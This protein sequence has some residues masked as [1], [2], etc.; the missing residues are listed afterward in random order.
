M[1]HKIYFLVLM[2]SFSSATVFADSLADYLMPVPKKMELRTGAFNNS[3]GRIIIPAISGNKSLLNIGET[4]QTLLSEINI[5][6]TVAAAGSRGEAPLV[7]VFLS[8][9]LSSQA[10]KITILSSQITIEGGDEE[11]LFYA[12][13]TFRQIVRYAKDAG[14]LPLVLIEDVPDFKRRGVMLDVSRNKVPT[15]STLKNL[16]ELFASWKLNELQLYTENTFAYEKHAAVWNGFS[17]LTAQEM[18]ELDQ[19]CRERFIDLVPNQTSFGHMNQW[20]VHDEY[21][22]LAE[23]TGPN[24]GHVMSPAQPGTMNLMRELYGELLPNF[25]SPYFNINCDEVQALGSGRSKQLV[26]G[27]GQGRVYV[28]YLLQL[29]NEVDKYGRTTQFWGDIILNHPEL[30]PEIPKNMITLVWGYESDY[31]FDTHCEKFKEAGCTFYVCPGTSSWRSLV[32][33]NQNAFDNLKNAARNGLKHGAMGF[34]NTDWGDYGHWQPLSVSYPTYLYGAAISWGFQGNE[35]IDV[36][37]LVSR[38]VLNDSTGRSGKALLD[39]GNAYLKTGDSIDFDRPLFHG[40]L[41][42]PGEE[43]SGGTTKKGLQATI[44]YL[45]KNLQILVNAPLRSEDAEIVKKE[46]ILAVNMAK[47]AC[48]VGL[49]RLGNSS[50]E[51]SKLSASERKTLVTEFEGLLKEFQQLWIVRNRPGGLHKSSAALERGL[52]ELKK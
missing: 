34:L 33:R 21:K 31:P 46:M 38:Y 43:I 29:K 7:S 1:K 12:L 37:K 41:S 10:Y 19:F 14:T 6:S 35:N 5:K 25:S 47:F 18:I 42:N 52:K 15:M 24:S 16:V 45:N 27:K 3:S 36:G 13:Q 22:E 20:L 30:I 4:L 8:P 23:L 2:L 51:L 9:R 49:T 50:H 11:G 32:G 40:L 28:D 44:D 48:K 39:L 17:P 26:D